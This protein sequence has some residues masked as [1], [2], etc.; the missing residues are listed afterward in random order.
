[1]DQKLDRFQQIVTRWH[2]K[3]IRM[4]GVILLLWV[5]L[6]LNIHRL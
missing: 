4:S 1:M 2:G 3:A 5:W 6:Q